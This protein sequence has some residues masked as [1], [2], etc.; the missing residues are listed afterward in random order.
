MQKICYP[1]ISSNTKPRPTHNSLAQSFISENERKCSFHSPIISSRFHSAL[2]LIAVKLSSVTFWHNCFTLKTCLPFFGWLI[3][4]CEKSSG[5][6][7][8]YHQH[9]INL[10]EGKRTQLCYE[11]DKAKVRKRRDAFT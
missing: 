6:F 4:Y 1:S 8:F 3:F 11:Y 2:L 9:N 7:G 10:K 5:N